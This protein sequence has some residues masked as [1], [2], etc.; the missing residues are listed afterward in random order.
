MNTI[1]PLLILVLIVGNA[2]AQSP[3]TDRLKQLTA[4]LQK[5]TTDR[6]LREQIIKLALETKPPPVIPR[7]AKELEGAAEYFASSAKTEADFA[8]AAAEFEKATLIAPWAAADYYNAAIMY[9]KAKLPE[10]ALWNYEFYLLAA[11][12][13]SDADAVIKKVGGMKAAA[14]IAA[15]QR[16]ADEERQRLAAAVA[17]REYQRTAGLRAFRANVESKSYKQ[18]VCGLTPTGSSA[19]CTWNE[20]NGKNWRESCRS[21]EGRSICDRYR[22][23]FEGDAGYLKVVYTDSSAAP[24][25]LVKV[26]ANGPR[27]EDLNWYTPDFSSGNYT[28]VSK[29]RS[30]TPLNYLVLIGAGS[31]FTVGFVKAG[32]TPSVNPS[33][34]R[35]YHLYRP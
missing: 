21:W 15:E 20:Y 23:E 10:K 9:E 8:K 18:Y 24:Q 3:P 6:A 25:Y 29:Y 32:E 13:A 7:E 4:D 22:W 2:T 1:L 12:N 16:A 35:H 33:A 31:E 30:W 17:D 14:R 26:V 28:D 27:I 34:R 19:G 5:A 11:P